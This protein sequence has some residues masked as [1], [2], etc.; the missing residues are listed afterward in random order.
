MS[1]GCK[2]LGPYSVYASATPFRGEETTLTNAWENV[3]SSDFYRNVMQNMGGPVGGRSVRFGTR[4]GGSW[5]NYQI[6]SPTGD[7]T[8]FSGQG[9]RPSRAY[10]QF[11]EE[12]LSRP[13][14]FAEVQE[15]LS[16][17]LSP[18]L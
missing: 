14:T 15:M 9:H 4:G 3:R 13:Y 12:N 8:C 6:S 17:S 5:A 18:R 2:D 1:L 11:R 16:R 7:V 10:A